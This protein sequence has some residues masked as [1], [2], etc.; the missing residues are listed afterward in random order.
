MG[1][2]GSGSFTDYSQHK[3][4]TP[5]EKNGGSSGIDKCGIAFSTNLEEVGRCFYFTTFGTVPVSGTS[6]IVSFKGTRLIVETIVGEE[7]GYLPTKFN[8]LKL[9]IDDGFSYGGVVT[10]SKNTP[11]AS[12]FVDIIPL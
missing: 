6:V 4:T 8:Y 7:I 3:P 5:E 1:S 2:S 12:I 9:C 10:N 11:T